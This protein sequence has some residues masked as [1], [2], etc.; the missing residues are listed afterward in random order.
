MARITHLSLRTSRWNNAVYE[1]ALFVPFLYH[2]QILE[3]A[4]SSNGEASAECTPLLS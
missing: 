3:I 4:A 1:N 2:L